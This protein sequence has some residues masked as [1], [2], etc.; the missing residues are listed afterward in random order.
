ME[1]NKEVDYSRIKELIA[2]VQEFIDTL[3]KDL[4]D[5]NGITILLLTNDLQNKVTGKYTLLNGEDERLSLVTLL[6]N[7]LGRAFNKEDKDAE[8]EIEIFN[9]IAEYMMLIC[10]KFPHLYDSF[11]EGVK[12][13]QENQKNED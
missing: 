5:E 2:K 1:T 3:P 7:C 10:A 6:D 9:S 12:K 11:C 4:D 8:R 13:Y